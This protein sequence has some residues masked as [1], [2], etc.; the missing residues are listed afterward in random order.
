MKK[1][2]LVTFM[3]SSAA[4]ANNVVSS[5]SGDGSG[6]N[7]KDEIP[8]HYPPAR[9]DCSAAGISI[10]FFEY[11]TNNQ[12]RK[13]YNGEVS[14]GPIGEQS[15]FDYDQ[16]IYVEL[17]N[18]G[19][20]LKGTPIESGAPTFEMHLDWVKDLYA[21]FI[22]VKETDGSSQKWNF[23]SCQESRFVSGF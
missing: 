21:G 13:R 10:T 20:D 18:N 1:F 14:F 6:S 7:Q 17:P 2:I 16:I 19:L 8:Y 12:N 15:G 3:F 11:A 4:F 5:S 9:L 23:R 22:I